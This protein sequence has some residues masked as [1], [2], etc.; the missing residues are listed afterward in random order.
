MQALAEREHS[1]SRGERMV[2]AGEPDGQAAHWVQERDDQGER[3][4]RAGGRIDQVEFP[5]LGD[6]QGELDE[7]LEAVGD[8]AYSGERQVQAGVR[9]GRDGHQEEV[10]DRGGLRSRLWGLGDQDVH[11]V[12]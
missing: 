2:R 3:Q 11:L 6:D 12:L 7:H 9:V 10:G 4:V 5:E 1:A 8:R